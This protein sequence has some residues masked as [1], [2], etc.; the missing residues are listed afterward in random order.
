MLQKLT[1]A[2]K[3]EAIAGYE[4]AVRRVREKAESKSTRRANHAAVRPE[5]TP[6]GQGAQKYVG[7]I[8]F[9]TK[10]KYTDR[11]NEYEKDVV[12]DWIG[13]RM[14]TNEDIE[15]EYNVERDHFQGLYQIEYI[16]RTDDAPVVVV[17][18]VNMTPV[19]IT[20]RR[21]RDR[22]APAISGFQ[23][24]RKGVPA[25]YP[26]RPDKCV[27]DF[28]RA[29]HGGVTGCK[30]VCL[31]DDNVA[32]A[33]TGTLGTYGSADY[34]RP[35][36]RALESLLAAASSDLWFQIKYIQDYGANA[37]DLAHYCRY[38][39][40]SLVQVDECEQIVHTVRPANA[41]KCL[42]PVIFRAINAHIY[43]VTDPKMLQS[44]TR[45]QPNTVG[46][47]M[48]GQGRSADPD[49]P[50]KERKHKPDIV[51][52]E[53]VED[54]RRF[55]C[56]LI[57]NGGHLPPA[58]GGTLTAPQEVHPRSIGLCEGAGDRT[59]VRS[60]TYCLDPEDTTKWTRYEI[61]SQAA[62]AKLIAA[63]A[64][65]D[66]ERVDCLGKV[67]TALMEKHCRGLIEST[68]N[69]LLARWF[70]A[71]NA[72]NREPHGLLSH[73]K[74]ETALVKDLQRGSAVYVDLNAAHSISMYLPSDEWVVFGHNDSPERYDGTP[75][76]ELKRGLYYVT[77]DN[78]NVLR[79][80]CFYTRR[81][82]Q[83]AAEDGVDFAIR[84]MAVA[85]RSLPKDL[86]QKLMQEIVAHT[87]TKDLPA[88]VSVNDMRRA[89]KRLRVSAFGML[90][91]TMRVD[92][93]R[94]ATVSAA[95]KDEIWSL[96][97]RSDVWSGTEWK[98]MVN[99]ELDGG[100][101]RLYAVKSQKVKL[102]HN[103]AIAF[104]VQDESHLRLLEMCRH[105]GGRPL[106]YRTDA[107]VLHRPTTRDA[108]P[109]PGDVI[110]PASLPQMSEDA[111]VQAEAEQELARWGGYKLEGVPKMFRDLTD[112][113]TPAAEVPFEAPAWIDHPEITDSGDYDAIT[114]L[115]LE[116]RGLFIAGPWGTGKSYWARMFLEKHPR[117]IA[118]APTHFA[119]TNLDGMTID[120][121]VGH[122][123][124]KH[125]FGRTGIA[126]DLEGV[127]GIVVDEV[128]MIGEWRL[129][130]IACLKAMKPGLIVIAM[131]DNEQLPPVKD[132]EFPYFEHP[133]WKAVVGGHR[134]T[135]TKIYRSD[136]RLNAIHKQMLEEGDAFKPDAHFDKNW[137]QCR[138]NLSWTND[139]A[140][141]VNEY[142]M[143]KEK[144]ESAVKVLSGGVIETIAW[145]YPGLP[146]VAKLSVKRNGA[147]T[148]GLTLQQAYKAKQLIY[149]MQRGVM[150]SVDA[151]GGKFAVHFPKEGLDKEWSIEDFHPHFRPGYCSTTHKAQG[152]TIDEHTAVWEWQKMPRRMLNTA[153]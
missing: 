152:E 131:G 75:V 23:W 129:Q 76:Q 44:I 71:P 12:A 49:A 55:L 144:P 141:H 85:S 20:K 35:S 27:F 92:F 103:A 84:S 18:K 5:P 74:T 113:M 52:V 25:N 82:L 96:A 1:P 72:R 16:K 97:A 112:T 62:I 10:I 30:A 43:P 70:T 39:N 102:E 81:L 107:A 41:G 4:E 119:A 95:H 51:Y 138:R 68:P 7:T 67:T 3:R 54:T 86:F 146:V 40:C 66:A 24:H 88:G 28:L 120:A 147:D 50:Q 89:R 105:F 33:M 148:R 83:F 134:I 60:V 64:G 42:P 38:V 59:E 61:N 133:T 22:A 19:A 94:A 56:D 65:I 11:K 121:L 57:H 111:D 48:K 45:R 145:L 17:D 98:T 109:A 15:R 108:R 2:K 115:A 21:M 125:T 87:H 63:R 93:S 118:V 153:L 80:D 8:T 128:S 99:M 37:E 26:C 34:V 90:M 122:N 13:D 130:M 77:T 53:D 114:K 126:R 150:T 100:A 47:V 137:Q 91:K 79:G 151:E 6:A 127:D 101:T 116:N 149:N 123:V 29:Y 31:S 9:K 32:L 142:W 69:P 36:K 46:V 110:D 140:D 139:V 14:P 136:A 124:A 117:F 58:Y 73:E 106:Y 104:Q 135:L 78:H 132:E 143:K